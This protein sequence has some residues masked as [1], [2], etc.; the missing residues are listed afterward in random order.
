[1]K[2]IVKLIILV[3][4]SS[5]VFTACNKEG[6]LPL[7]IAGNGT[8]VTSSAASVTAV[9]ADSS[10]TLLTVNWTWPN[11]A[12]DSA[13]QKFI[14]QIDSA[15]HNFVKPW[16]RTVKGV[17]STS[18]TAKELNNIV[19]GFG[20]VN[21]PYTLQM[22]IVSSYGNNNEQY[23]SN[24]TNVVVTPYIIPITLTLTPTA[25][26]T[27][28]MADATKMA[29]A[30]KWNATQ[31]GN[32]PLSYAV[33]FQ[34]AGGT[35]TAPVVKTF[36]SALAGTFTVTDLNR[37][38]TSC[39][40]AANTTDVLNIRVIASQ[41]SNFANPL[42]SN[43]TSLTV[44]TY[45]DVVKFWV[46]G[47]YN[48]W[49][50]SDKALYIINT[51]ESG[52]NA[53]GYVNFDAIGEFKLTSDHSWDDAH[54]FGD[55]GTNTGKLSNVGGGKNI[56]I[57]AAGYYLINA[58][59]VT[60]T[61]TLTPTVWGVI[62]S[63]TPGAWADQTNMT[64]N[65]NLKVFT[66]ALSMPLGEIKFRGTSSWS[67]NYGCTAK[68]GKTLDAGGTNIAV[69]LAADY[70]ITLDLSHPNAYTY[71]SNRWGVIGSATADGWN[72]DQNMTW[73]AANK[74]FTATIPL[75]AGEYKF[76][77]N[78]DWPVNFGGTLDALVQDG[79]NLSVAA[80]GTYKIT[81]DPWAKKATIT[82]A[83]KK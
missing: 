52:A 83:K 70:A 48:G 81:L 45:L 57:P 3:A 59:P 79:G 37:I 27:L 30:C 22:R 41:G 49:D 25:P 53:E 6:D 82:P 58:N 68:D 21:A 73:D 75:T 64:Y 47:G 62:G 7:Y 42:Y 28:L 67:V 56:S 72:S 51:P 29:L 78:D 11:Y 13:N 69:D 61:Y 71:S 44:T 5:M 54:T 63:A 80:A 20:D 4:L 32:Q 2:N 15:G 40:I 1:M 12:T 17:S 43:V 26:I 9:V 23:T 60:M 55:D 66:L 19:F 50:N 35:W 39:G 31:Y 34:K 65:A 10:K 24:T 46:V 14:L 36:G 33:Q 18:F 8:V 74:V 76:R 38:A 16:T 77:A